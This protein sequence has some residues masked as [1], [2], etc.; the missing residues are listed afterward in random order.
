MTAGSVD[1][2]R[3]LSRQPLPFFSSGSWHSSRVAEPIEVRRPS[4]GEVMA[5]V[6]AA[7]PAEVAMAVD[8][9]RA[10]D[11]WSHLTP[12][13]RADHLRRLAG[14]I[15]RDEALLATLE[16][17]NLG[18]R[19]EET[20]GFDIRFAADGYRY[21]ADLVEQQQARRDLSLMGVDAYT[22]QFPRG[23]CGFIIPWNA[24]FVLLAWGI[25]P[26]LAAGNRVVA[27]LPELAPLSCLY[28]GQLIEEAGFPAGTVNL[29]VGEGREAGAAL[30]SH[31]GLDFLSFTGS[32]ETGKSVALAAA[33]HLTPTKLELGGK[34]A[35]IVFSDAD[36]PSTAEQLAAA[37]TRNA[38]QTCCTATRWLVQAEVYDEFLDA[39]KAALAAV[40][41]GADCDDEATMGPVISESQLRRIE[42]LIDQGVTSGA[43]VL[44]R[45]EQELGPE[46]ESGYF[47][48]PQLL[49]GGLDNVC[50][51]QE[52][53]GPVAYVARF[54]DAD[55]AVAAVNSSS[56]GLAN[57]V[58]TADLDRARRVGSRLVAANLWINAHNLFVYGLPYGGVGLSGW[59]GGVNSPQTLRD[60]Q[61]SLSVAMPAT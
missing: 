13:D 53:F 46:W 58:W 40:V 18:K 61:R 10:S 3:F 16:S 50:A 60:Y 23:V 59:G 51:Q 39:V 32:P 27:K 8:A 2:A 25:A 17:R 45:G 4:N 24:P 12:Q 30:A 31:P 26:A 57:S 33:A 34:G 52:I 29:L 21:F 20:L 35:A 1:A 47:V 22:E 14:L 49:S 9:A 44:F 42:G 7:S 41:V 5:V 15:D 19:F 43:R 11:S 37:I 54:S 55:E 56:Y 48:R 6:S 28:L 38:G 36:V